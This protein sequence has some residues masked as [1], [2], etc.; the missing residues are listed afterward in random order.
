MLPNITFTNI[1]AA[2]DFSEYRS[3]QFQFNRRQQYEYEMEPA[4]KKYMIIRLAQT[5]ED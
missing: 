4:E 5:H 3:G 2:T 1:T